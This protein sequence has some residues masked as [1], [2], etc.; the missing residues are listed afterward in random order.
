MELE[1]EETIKKREEKDKK[2]RQ[3]LELAEKTKNEEKKKL[4]IL[5]KKEEHELLQ[6]EKLMKL[7]YI[8]N[9]M[10]G[11]P[12]KFDRLEKKLTKKIFPSSVVNDLEK[13]DDELTSFV[14]TSQIPALI[15]EIKDISLICSNTSSDI[16]I[17]LELKSSLIFFLFSWA[18]KSFCCFLVVLIVASSINID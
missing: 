10:I 5:K 13:I 1:I 3:E 6:N 11:D 18:N 16:V 14:F 8:S 12:F 2:K 15:Y 4:E 7:K 9:G 17:K